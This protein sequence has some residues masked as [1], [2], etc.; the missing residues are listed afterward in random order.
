MLFFWANNFLD[1]QPLFEHSTCLDVLWHHDTFHQPRRVGDHDSIHITGEFDMTPHDLIV[2]HDWFGARHQ[3]GSVDW[4]ERAKVRWRRI[5][6]CIPVAV[7]LECYAGGGISVLLNRLG[8]VGC[9][10][11]II[12]HCAQILWRHGRVR[13]LD[14]S[15][16]L[17]V[18]SHPRFHLDVVSCRLETKANQTSE[19]WNFEAAVSSLQRTPEISGLHNSWWKTSYFWWKDS[20]KRSQ[21]EWIPEISIAFEL[22]PSNIWNQLFSAFSAAF[23]SKAV[24]LNEVRPLTN[25]ILSQN[26]GGRSNGSKDAYNQ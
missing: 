19:S 25:L 9:R 6:R 5:P 4:G 18:S 8:K 15:P 3:P 13:L 21:H 11:A 22:E 14:E 16:V 2:T 23:N 12:S 10:K 17:R 26:Q 1:L 7:V 24:I 20:K